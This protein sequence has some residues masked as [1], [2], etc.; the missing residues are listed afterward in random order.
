MTRKNE[1]WYL[2]T[3]EDGILARP[4]RS[5]REA[6]GEL[7][8]GGKWQHAKNEHGVYVYLNISSAN[9]YYIGREDNLRAQGLVFE[10]NIL[11]GRAR[12]AQLRKNGTLRAHQQHAARAFSAKYGR[13]RLS[14]KVAAWRRANRSDVEREMDMLLETLTLGSDMGD[15]KIE[16]MPF[17]DDNGRPY[18]L[19]YAW[20]DIM[21]AI[22]INGHVH[23]VFSTPHRRQYEYSRSGELRREGWLIHTISVI[24]AQEIRTD[25]VMQE[26]HLAL[27]MV[28]SM[29]KHK[30]EDE[31]ARIADAY[32]YDEMCDIEEPPL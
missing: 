26:I 14:Q 21:V 11:A 4:Y 32:T 13:A 7:P 6:I 10:K 24:N 31:R 25:F 28:E 30:Q 12:M 19:D 20:P 29:R 3:P 22:E 2:A 18:I 23:E 16:Y 8:S 9:T 5:R 17:G 27:A 15:Y 1:K